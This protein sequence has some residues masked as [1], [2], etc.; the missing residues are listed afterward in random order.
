MA[1]SALDDRSKPAGPNINLARIADRILRYWYMVVISLAISLAMAYL[2]NRYTTRIYPVSASIIIRES[3]ENVGAKFLYNNSLISPYRNY[4]NE[5]FIM[6]SYPLMQQVVEDLGLDVSYSLKGEIKNTERYMPHFPVKIRPALGQRLPYGQSF[7]YK[8]VSETEFTLAGIKDDDEDGAATRYRYND[9]ILVG[10]ARVCFQKN[11]PLQ[12]KWIGQEF[13]VT[14]Q[15]PYQLAKYYSSALQLNWAE[16][17]AAVVNLYL[18]GPLAEKEKDFMKK[19]IEYY[20]RYDVQKKTTMAAKSIEFMDRQVK[21]I[22]DSL[23]QYEEKIARITLGN[24]Q[25]MEQG[26][27]RITT[28]GESLDEKDIQIRLQ[29]RYYSYLETYMNSGSEFDQVLL[30]SSL[31]VSDPV[32]SGL[33]SKLAGLQFELRVLQ[34]QMRTNANPLVQESKERIDLYKR[35]IAE[36]IRSAKEIMR[37]NRNL[38][39]ER[40]KELENS[41]INQPEPDKTLS[42]VQRNYK[43]NE[44]LYM[45]L[46]QKRAEAAISQA[47]ATSDIIVVNY[48]EAGGAIAPVPIRNYTYGLAIGLLVPLALFVLLEF[49]DDKVQ[50]KEDIE[51]VCA[52][53][54]IGTIGHN[55]NATSNLAVLDKPRSYLA[56]SFRALRSNLN[57]FTEG[58]D[59]KV[60]LITSSI[61]GEGK[62]FTSINMSI[63]MAFTG[64]RVVLIGGDMRKSEITKDFEVSNKM[65]LSLYLSAQATVEQIILK[66][67]VENLDF[68]PP[69]PT[70]PNPAELYLN[71]RINDLFTKLLETYDYVMVDSPP[72]G[73]VSDALALIPIVD[74]VLF[75]ARQ[76]YTPLTAISQLQFMVDQGQVQHVSIVLNDIQRMGMGYGYKYGYAYDYGYGYRYGQN[77]YGYGKKYGEGYGDDVNYGG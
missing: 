42:N 49:F 19:F 31:G 27:K 5:F 44:Q 29:E 63:V 1:Q 4:Y 74:H 16:Q 6:R 21:N 33:V 59:K 28:L 7:R 68:I 60:I 71:P 41:L 39:R 30:P 22:S 65:G 36:G 10:N 35:D 3:D 61:S 24:R 26:I 40:M 62:T 32:L 53:P 18:Q 66:T 20:Q 54:V 77:R 15:D 72:V 43:L 75:V 12:G 2:A 51:A 55:P 48:P 13:M 73:L 34:D 67:K 25:G 57:Y 38:Y 46:V 70:P 56:E 37:I 23:R 64:K 76:N 45:F 52:V 47:S 58:K 50:S 14:F 11:N 8:L 69:G 9:T 17:G